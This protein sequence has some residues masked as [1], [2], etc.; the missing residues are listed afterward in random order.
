VREM[1]AVRAVRIVTME[2]LETVLRER[3]DGHL[4]FNMSPQAQQRK[5]YKS[6]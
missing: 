2:A 5:T 6:P 3:D 1:E 4:H